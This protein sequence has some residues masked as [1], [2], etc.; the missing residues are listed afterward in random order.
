[1][2][3]YWEVF[4]QSF[5]NFGGYVWREITFQVDPWYVNYFWWLIV[6]SLVVWGLEILFSMEEEPSQDP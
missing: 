1:M 5:S 6:L 2:E 4:L 3:R